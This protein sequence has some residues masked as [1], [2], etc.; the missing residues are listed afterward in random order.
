MRA[1]TADAPRLPERPAKGIPQSPDGWQAELRQELAHILSYWKAHAVDAVNGGFAGR[2]DQA[3]RVM[4]LAP[5]GM[6]LHARILWT[7]ATAYQYLGDA[8]CLV[9]AR[10]AYDYL[11]EN[12]LDKEYGG[13]YWTVQAT[14]E[15]LEIK[16]QLYGQ[17][18]AVYGL[19]AYYACTGETAA[20]QL[21]RETFHLLERHGFD[22]QNGGYGEAFGRNWQPLAD[23]RL[24]EKDAHADKTLNTHLH[25]LEA[26]TA[27][28]QVD[29]GAGLEGSIRRL[30]GNFRDHFLDPSGER[31]RLFF[32]ADWQPSSELVSYGHEIEASWL[33]VEAARVV[34]DPA[35]E[36]AWN[37]PALGLARGARVG[38]DRDGGLWYEWEPARGLVR[39]KHWWAQAEAMVGF[40][41]AWQLGGESAFLSLALESWGFIKACILDRRG[42]EWWWGVD[43]YQVPMEGQDKVGPWKCPYHNAR[44]CLEILVR[45]DNT[46]ILP[47]SWPPILQDPA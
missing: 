2:I 6:V 28:Y 29:P 45:L 1:A 32:N 14:G 17:A 44:A 33:L 13:F 5:K 36:S 22:P 35:L 19:C 10:R 9:M 40:F 37:A 25:I 46:T 3:G 11:R 34:R 20:L 47:S 27:L 42:G 43:A 38:L 16:K 7:F 41:N 21:A 12:F 15:P 39:E 23:R 31:L 26:Y 8:S 4:P 18:F 24:S 30:L